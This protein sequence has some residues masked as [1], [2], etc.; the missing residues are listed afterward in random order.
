LIA[1]TF[2]DAEVLYPPAG[3]DGI[4]EAAIIGHLDNG[5]TICLTQ[6]ADTIV[7]NPEAV[8]ELFQMLRRLKEKSAAAR[9]RQK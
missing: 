7:I 1:R 6:E 5:G 2:N 4:C 3:D 9:K 8:D